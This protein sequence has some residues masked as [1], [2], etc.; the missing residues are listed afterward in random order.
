MS[1][2]TALCR[3]KTHELMKNLIKISTAI[4]LFGA[5]TS[6]WAVGGGSVLLTLADAGNGQTTLSWTVGGGFTSYGISALP[7]GFSGFNPQ[8]SG[9]VNHLG[10]Y[11]DPIAVS[12]FGTFTDSSD[13]NTATLANIQVVAD[14][15]STYS[16]DLNT[17]TTLYGGGGNPTVI[18]FAPGADSE[19]IDVPLSTFNPGT[20]TYSTSYGQDGFNSSMNYTLNVLTPT[21]EP[22][23][24]ALGAIGLGGLIIARR[25][26]R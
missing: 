13:A 25:R 18:Y 24:M 23:T 9:W 21:P 12:G 10:S 1:L 14:G 19:T 15:G 17:G 11:T 20:Y 22:S 2:T 4:A 3:L 26:N 7:P 6:A 5:I 8:F 16:F